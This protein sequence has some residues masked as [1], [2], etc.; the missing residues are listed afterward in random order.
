MRHLILAF[1]VFGLATS[2]SSTKDNVEVNQSQTEESIME[3]TDRVSQAPVT[4]KEL[5]KMDA[6]GD[7]FLDKSELKGSMLEQF[8]VIDTDNDGLMSM[9]EFEKKPSF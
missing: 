3:V 2:C 8:D 4:A 5:W 9:E 7:G 1:L 6:D